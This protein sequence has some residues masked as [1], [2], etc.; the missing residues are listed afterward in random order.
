MKGNYI[1]KKP[2]GYGAV[3][4]SKTGVWE[5][6]DQGQSV[7]D[8]QWSGQPWE[9]NNGYYL[10][11]KWTVGLNESAVADVQFNNDGTKLYVIGTGNDTIYQYSCSTAWDVS[12]ASY[13]SKSFSVNTQEGTPHGLFFKSDGTKFYVVGSINDTVYQYSCSTAWDISTAFYDRKSFY[14]GT[15]DL[16]SL[17]LFFKSDGTKFYTAGSDSGTV[18]QYSCSTAWDVST[19]SYES[20]SFSVAAQESGLNGVFFK[21]DGTKFYIVGT[22]ND[23]VYQYSCSTA[24]DVSTGSYD[25]KLCR[26]GTIE[27]NPHGLCF[28]SDGTKLYVVGTTLSSVVEFSLS[29]AW[30]VSTNNGAGGTFYVG[31]QDS[32][33]GEMVFKPD[34]TK[35]YVVGFTNDRVYQYACATAW[36]ITT[37]SYESKSFLVSTEELTAQGLFFK[38]DGTK[39]YV[40]G[41]VNKT[42]YQ[43]S[44]ST[45]WD[46]STASYDSKFFSVNAQDTDPTGLFFKPDG[47]KFYVVGNTNNTIYQ[48]S[49]ATAWD[50]STASYDSKSFNV[51][52]Q[53]TGPQVA[54]FKPDGT[55]FYIADSGISVIFQYACSTAWDVSTASYSNKSVA[56]TNDNSMRSLFFKSDGLRFY[57]L[58]QQNLSVYQYNLPLA[59]DVV[60]AGFGAKLFPVNLQ[61][62]SPTDLTFSSDGTKFYLIGITRDTVY[63]YTC[64]TAWD[65]T[66][67]SFNYT[68]SGAYG[69]ARVAGQETNPQGLFFKSDGTAFYIV[70]STADTVY[71]YTCF[72][73]WDV[74]T[75][76]YASKSFSVAVQDGTPTGLFFKPDGTKFYIVGSTNDTVY[77]YSCST[78]WDISTASYDTKSFGVLAQESTPLGLFFKSDGAKFY[79]VGSNNDTVYQYSCSTA[80]DISTASYDSKSF[81]VAGQEAVPNGLAFNDYG[82]YLYICGST[83]PQGAYQ[84]SLV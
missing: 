33:L 71:Q 59:W 44:C 41:S 55:V 75:A 18:Y 27:A 58:G 60:N 9:V 12:T 77:Q 65:I 82:N 37:A 50:V 19:A 39:F 24:W 1:G 76:S 14:V 43:Y 26:V 35:F 11:K 5:I 23:T 29:T 62:T 73:A 57:V 40:V 70:G 46:V 48:Y 2:S 3:P 8:S 17:G 64:S 83:S 34:G 52:T 32:N 51:N 68:S 66:T 25:T 61:E 13:D 63:Q 7:R 54:F 81:S 72:T 53:A 69:R 4:A 74:S 6:Y 21:S 31:G 38:D 67:A 16:T 30:D 47:L 79:I 15:Q 78:A 42:V 80:W 84:Y 49:C 22:A 45:A 36:D 10:N 56:F 28:K 20:K